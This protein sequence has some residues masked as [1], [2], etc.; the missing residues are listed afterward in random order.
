MIIKLW[1]AA[2]AVR[3]IAVVIGIFRRA[4]LPWIVWASF[5]EI[6]DLA[7]LSFYYA[8]LFGPHGWYVRAT[9]IQQIGS[10]SLLAWIVWETIKPPEALICAAS[11]VTFIFGIVLCTVR[12]FPNSP[13]EPVL[14]GT[15]LVALWM[16][17]MSAVIAVATFRADR[18]IL[19]TYLIL[20]AFLSLASPDYLQRAGL[21]RAWEIL[22]IAAFTAWGVLWWRKR[23]RL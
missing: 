6:T 5:V 2:I 1:I 23:V 9:I 13:I 11:I 7:A 10:T 14:I 3:L 12:N 17:G 20:L 22:E 16:G 4:P 15:G 21:G 19:A 8:K 18:Y